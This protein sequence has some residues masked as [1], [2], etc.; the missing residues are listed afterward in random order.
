MRKMEDYDNL[1]PSIADLLDHSL[2][3][4]RCFPVLGIWGR[5]WD[6][7]STESEMW[8]VT[9]VAIFFFI[10]SLKDHSTEGSI[11]GTPQ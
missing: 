7:I 11:K 6:W 5:L 3:L 2:V 4:P 9:I 8:H 10:C 1:S